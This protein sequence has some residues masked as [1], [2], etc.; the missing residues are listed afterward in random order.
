M[1]ARAWGAV[2]SAALLLVSGCS[3]AVEIDSPDVDD[4]TR[5]TCESFLDAL[6]DTLS[7]ESSVDVEPDD[8]LGRAWGDPPI[9]VT[10]GVDKAEGFNKFSACWEAN[11]VG[12]YAPD[13]QLTDPAADMV[14]TTI[15]FTP[16]VEIRVPGELRPPDAVTV[17][18][19]T[20]VKKHLE[21]DGH[22]C[23]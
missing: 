10:C 23:V 12:F 3:G 19:G 7:G 14:L 13:D 2:A 21:R 5:A 17:D 11:G 16:R 1:P 6:P 20:A 15:G 9:V 8:A 18:V 4:A 22:P